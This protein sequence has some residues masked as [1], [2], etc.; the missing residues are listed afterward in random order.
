M[1][2]MPLAAILSD[3]CISRSVRDSATW[4]RVTE[5]EGW[6]GP[7]PN[8]EELAG[9]SPEKLRIGHY[10]TD[11]FGNAPDAV[12]RDAHERA[13]ALCRSLGHVVVP[14]E[15]PRFDGPEASRAVYDV[16]AM[17]TAGIAASFA[18]GLAP[19]ATSDARLAAAL[20]AVMG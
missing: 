1:T 8:A 15:S 11:G 18:L 17:A 12:T 13:V 19:D 9:N 20:G 10:L 16:M 2:N 5:A 14:V 3:H 6:S 7:L 4:L